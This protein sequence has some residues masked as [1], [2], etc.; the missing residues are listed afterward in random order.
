MR[1]SDWSSDVCSSDLADRTPAAPVPTGSPEAARRLFAMSKPITGTVAQSYLRRRGITDVRHGDPLRFHPRC[2]YRGD[3]EDPR[4]R[5]RDA[6]PAIIAAVTDLDG[7]I[8]GA[9]RTWLDPSGSHKADI[10]T[11][12]RA[13]GQ[14][15]G[16]AVR[17]GHAVDVL[18]AGEGIETM[19]SEAHTSDLQ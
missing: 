7:T 9:H 8:S 10:P 15:L 1:I 4:D 5:L 6:W 12:R 18:V 14:P 17:F 2:W 19:R 13:M 3:D 11:P 16:N